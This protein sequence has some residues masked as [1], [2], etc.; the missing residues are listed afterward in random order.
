MTSMTEPQASNFLVYW[1]RAVN[2]DVSINCPSS[3]IRVLTGGVLA[4]RSPYG[5]TAMTGRWAYMNDSANG[6]ATVLQR[7]D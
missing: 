4:G 6:C 5:F 7:Y 3:Q 1:R 2:A